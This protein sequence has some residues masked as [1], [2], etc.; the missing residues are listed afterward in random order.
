MATKPLLDFAALL[1]PIPG[2]NPAGEAL[3]Y[4]G[5]YDELKG[6]LPKPDRDAFDATIIK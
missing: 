5:D 3:R 4:A 1:A 2:D 6:L